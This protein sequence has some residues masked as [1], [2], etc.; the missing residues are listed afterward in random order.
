[1]VF[2]AGTAAALSAQSGAEVGP[3]VVSTAGGTAKT[4]Q[5]QVSWTLGELAVGTWT[6]NDGR[7]LTEGFHQ[8]RLQV[9]PVLENAQLAVA[10]LPNPVQSLLQVQV[11]QKTVQPLGATLVD[12]QGRQLLQLNNLEVGTT[13]IDFSQYPGGI[14]LLHFHYSQQERPVETFKVVKAN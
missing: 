14:Y 6:L 7:I 12:L 10:I 11:S 9:A 8:P 2:A 5:I 3:Q 1:M 4:A 13:R